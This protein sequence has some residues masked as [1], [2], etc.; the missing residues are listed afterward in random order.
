MTPNGTLLHSQTSAL[1][2]HRQRR[3]L[4]QQ[5]GTGA[6]T[7]SQTLCGGL[8]THRSKLHLSIKSLPSELREPSRRGGG[9]SEKPEGDRGHQN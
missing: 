8:G 5:M 7:H 6:E 1:L 4:L 2:S 9:K 3:C